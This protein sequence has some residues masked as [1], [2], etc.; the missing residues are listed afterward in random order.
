[1]PSLGSS[2]CYW[3]FPGDLEPFVCVCVGVCESFVVTMPGNSTEKDGAGQSSA[4]LGKQ[5][6]NIC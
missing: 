3:T 4:A 1:M 5:A 2:P 6:I